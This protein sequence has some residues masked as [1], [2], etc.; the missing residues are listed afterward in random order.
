MRVYLLAGNE[1][2]GTNAFDG[3]IYIVTQL[4]HRWKLIFRF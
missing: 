4:R 1:S 3:R 2:H